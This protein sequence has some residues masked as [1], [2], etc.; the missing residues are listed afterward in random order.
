MSTT[1]EHAPPRSA[2]V[3]AVQ[4]TA[5]GGGTVVCL[6]LALTSTLLLVLAAVLGVG[7][8]SG[9]VASHRV[10]QYAIGA[11]V[12][13]VAFLALGLALQHSVGRYDA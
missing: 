1:T 6:G 8:L 9:F 5:L 2:A 4:L 11:G 12:A 13:W 10:Q 7:D 3:H